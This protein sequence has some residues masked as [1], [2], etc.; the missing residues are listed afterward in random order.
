MLCVRL[1]VVVAGL[2]CGACLCGTPWY[3]DYYLC[4]DLASRSDCDRNECVVAACADYNSCG[5]SGR[6]YAH[7]EPGVLEEA[8]DECEHRR[9]TWSELWVTECPEETG[10]DASSSEATDSTTV[11][12]STQQSEPS[13]LPWD[14]QVSCEEW[15]E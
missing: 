9:A 5:T 3:D 10:D 15:S 14:V 12:D 13:F 7:V 6:A 4:E 11:P 8:R 1:V 2:A